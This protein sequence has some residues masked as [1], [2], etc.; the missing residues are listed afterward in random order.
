MKKTGFFRILMLASI[1][2]VLLMGICCAAVTVD[3][4]TST[5]GP[6]VTLSAEV[7]GTEA[8]SYQWYKCDDVQGTNPKIIEDATSAS[9]TTDYLDAAGERYYKVVVN[10]T[11]SAVAT[12]TATL[13]TQ[14]VVFKFNNSADLDY[15]S[16]SGETFTVYKG[17]PCFSY[18]AAADGNTNFTASVM[19][20]FYLQGYPYIVVSLAT[21]EHTNNTLDIYLG[22][23]RVPDEEKS[24]GFSA[25]FTGMRT[26][27][28][29]NF[30]KLIVDVANRTYKA[31]SGNTVKNS[32][33]ASGDGFG[34]YEKWLGK[35]SAF[36]VDFSNQNAGKTA[37]AE[38]VGFFPT[39]EAA[40]AYA[41]AM[42]SDDVAADVLDAIGTNLSMDYTTGITE[43]SVKAYAEQLVND[44]T[45]NAVQAAECDVEI[46]V[47]DGKYTAAE[48]YWESGSYTFTVNVLAGEMPFKHS[49]VSDEFTMTVNGK[50]IGDVFVPDASIALGDSAKLT[51]VINNITATS[52]AW[53]KCNDAEGTGAVAISGA[54]GA[55]YETGAINAVGTYYYK[56]VVNGT[57]EYVCAVIVNYPTDPVIFKF[58]NDKDVTSNFV[59]VDGTPA[60]SYT[61]PES[62]DGTIYM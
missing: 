43:A 58:N 42:P 21:P 12:V 6:K 2:S 17:V 23:D 54:N 26:N 50:D 30:N 29:G 51:A 15:W 20:D 40:L 13:P 62:N 14:P 1:L 34:G 7:T 60:R 32:G 9:Y 24:Y 3:D 56:L 41:G 53:Y 35:L 36:R 11:D 39:E 38:Y 44:L 37:Y 52:Y 28:D 61:H 25:A 55:T 59:N 5:V 57:Q 46:T 19:N 49:L 48:N 47:T 45:E 10:G 18:V 27:D 31:Y 33:T 22:S 16:V 4:V 8:T